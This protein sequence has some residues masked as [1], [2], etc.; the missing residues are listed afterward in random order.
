[1]FRVLVPAVAARG[2]VAFVGRSGTG[3]EPAG[4]VLGGPVMGWSL[5]HE[6]A[7]TKLAYGVANTDPLALMV[8]CRPGD[9]T[10][11]VY[12]DGQ[13]DGARAV[14]NEGGSTIDP[15]AGG[16]AVETRLAVSDPALQNPAL[17]G[18]SAVRGDAGRLPIAASPDERRLVGEFLAYC[19]PARV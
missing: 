18:R 8:S 11:V 9:A 3:T 14:G 2:P 12:D 1:M 15:L 17:P 5:H 19:S 10:A 6:D 16:A 7:Q 13:P 4:T